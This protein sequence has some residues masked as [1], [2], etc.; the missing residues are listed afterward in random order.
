M[1]SFHSINKLNGVSR[2]EQNR[3]NGRTLTNN[4]TGL[5]IMAGK[6]SEPIATGKTN[7][8]LKK[9]GTLQFWI[10]EGK[11]ERS[12]FTQGTRYSL[13]SSENRF[14]IKLDKNGKHAVSTSKHIID[15][16]ADDKEIRMG[17]IF[18]NWKTDPKVFISYYVGKIVVTNQ[19]FK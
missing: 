15:R 4:R 9:T 8:R 10:Q 1:S 2:I 17:D 19:P 13:T 12:G 16:G 6:N 3:T 11:P 5:I 7:L 18:P 14:E